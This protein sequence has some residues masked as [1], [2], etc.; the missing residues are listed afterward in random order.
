LAVPILVLACFLPYERWIG[1]P[2]YA[3]N[4]LLGLLAIAAT[5][6]YVRTLLGGGQGARRG[7]A[8]Q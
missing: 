6:V 3:V 2:G 7:T 1:S 4:V 5:A 8:S